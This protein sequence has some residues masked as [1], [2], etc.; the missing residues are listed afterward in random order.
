MFYKLYD[1]LWNYESS[2]EYA[3]IE[4]MR[5]IKRGI[6]VITGTFIIAMFTLEAIRLFVI[7]QHIQNS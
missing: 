5:S 2:N 7:Y 4:E 1:L 6:V 3:H